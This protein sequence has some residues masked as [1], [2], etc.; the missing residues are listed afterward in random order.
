MD[1]AVLLAAWVA[2]D[3]HKSI[4]LIFT[5][6]SKAMILVTGSAGFIG[7]NFVLDW[8]A[9]HD[10]TVISLDK[11]TYA[12]N[13]ENLASLKDDPRHIF[14]RVISVMRS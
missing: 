10:E 12:G 8:C 1:A 14:V 9:Q 4:K 7:A 3:C 6:V 11:L 5:E 2:G 13:L